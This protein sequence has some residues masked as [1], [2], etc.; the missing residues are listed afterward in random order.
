MTLD[1]LIQMPD[2]AVADSESDS[3]I[4]H[5]KYKDSHV[6]IWL[7][8]D[9]MH[10]EW[11]PYPLLNGEWQVLVESLQ[12]QNDGSIAYHEELDDLYDMNLEEIRT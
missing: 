12:L 4:Y 10:D 8:W 9:V 6:E 5:L 3:W 2:L 1:Q 7:V 11:E